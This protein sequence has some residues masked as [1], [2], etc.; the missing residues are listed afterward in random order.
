MCVTGVRGVCVTGVRV[1]RPK[2]SKLIPTSWSCG[3]FLIVVTST[4]ITSV[5]TF[6]LRLME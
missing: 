3:K 6:S 1:T 4:F 2:S 5:T